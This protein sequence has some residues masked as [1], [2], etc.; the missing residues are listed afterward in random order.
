MRII[1]LSYTAY[2]M[3]AKDGHNKFCSLAF[4][5]AQITCRI[6]FYCSRLLCAIQCRGQ[7]QFK[8]EGYSYKLM[9][10]GG[11]VWTRI[12]S[13]IFERHLD[14]FF[15][16]LFISPRNWFSYHQFG[17]SFL[18]R[19]YGWELTLLFVGHG[20]LLAEALILDWLV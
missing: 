20:V 12:F 15:V 5:V 7:R 4:L 13:I 10:K 14:L 18:I 3:F 11:N 8:V 16:Q 6:G 19:Q 1:S 9:T 2:I 17:H